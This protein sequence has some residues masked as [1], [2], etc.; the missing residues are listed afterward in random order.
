MERGK[1]R[2]PRNAFRTVFNLIMATKPQH[3]DVDVACA[4]SI[5]INNHRDSGYNINSRSGSRRD[6]EELASRQRRLYRGRS[7]SAPSVEYESS[8]SED[9][10]LS[11]GVSSYVRRRSSC[12]EAPTYTD[13]EN[14]EESMGNYLQL[15]NHTAVII[16]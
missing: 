15:P 10:L 7:M 11:A 5:Y 6:G 9:G 13:Y 14:T 3:K 2:A 8:A 4:P 12:N 16:L 1:P